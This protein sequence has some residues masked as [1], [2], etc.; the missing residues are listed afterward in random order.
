MRFIKKICGKLSYKITNERNKCYF[1]KKL[2]GE[3]VVA[4]NLI[5]LI[6]FEIVFTLNLIHLPN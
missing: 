3:F 6:E 1:I 5:K 2:K 4:I